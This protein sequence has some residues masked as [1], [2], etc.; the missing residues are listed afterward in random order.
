MK[1]E[2]EKNEMEGEGKEGKK[3][4]SEG[5]EG[6]ETGRERG[7]RAERKRKEVAN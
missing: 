4:E 2:N 1:G 5:R 3:E 6:K 7:G